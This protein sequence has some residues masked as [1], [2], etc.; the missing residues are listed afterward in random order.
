MKIIDLSKTIKYNKQDP[1]FMQVKVKHRPHKRAGLLIR[2][3][4]LPSKLFPKGFLGWADDVITKMGVHSTTHIDAPWHYSSTCN[5]EKSKTIDE[6]PLDLCFAQGIV[7][8]MEH[9]ADFDPI[10]PEDIKNF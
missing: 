5:G 3:L 1:Y 9:K 2:L 4:G 6:M 8:N 7:I 10:T